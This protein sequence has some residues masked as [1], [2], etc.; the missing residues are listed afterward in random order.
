MKGKT[1][2]RGRE[3]IKDFL[4]SYNEILAS[5]RNVSNSVLS[6]N[7]VIFGFVVFTSV[8][9]CLCVHVLFRKL[10]LCPECQGIFQPLLEKADD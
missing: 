9:V 8:C 10:R 5:I 7:Y 1:K 6:S 3:E 2:Y 4:K